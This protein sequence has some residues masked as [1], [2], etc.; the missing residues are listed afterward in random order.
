VILSFLLF[1]STESNILLDLIKQINESTKSI[2]TIGQYQ[3]TFPTSLR[4]DKTTFRSNISL[5]SLITKPNSYLYNPDDDD[6]EEV[7]LNRVKRDS[8]PFVCKSKILDL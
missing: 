8:T 4:N 7:L 3:S 2:N 5:Q 6:D 1:N